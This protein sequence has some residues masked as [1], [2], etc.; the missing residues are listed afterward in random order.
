MNKRNVK[1]FYFFIH[2]NIKTIFKQI[3]EVKSEIKAIHKLATSIELL[4]QKMQSVDEKVGSIDVRLDAIE[5]RPVEDMNHYKRT[6]ISCI[7]TGVIA[8]ILG[9]VFALIL[10]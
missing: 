9:A 1:S 8:A 6:I 3:E 10:K 2:K 5:K 4:A 7:A